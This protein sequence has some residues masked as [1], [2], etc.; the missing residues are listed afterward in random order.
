[1][2]VLPWIPTQTSLQEEYE[3]RHRSD[4]RYEREQG[5][6]HARLLRIGSASALQIQR[7]THAEGDQGHGCAPGP[8]FKCRFG[9]LWPEKVLV[10]PLENREDRGSLKRK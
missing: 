10:H 5:M 2:P 7:S 4:E 6:L 8:P 9:D 1:M 3:H